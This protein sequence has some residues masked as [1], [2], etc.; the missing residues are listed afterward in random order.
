[1]RIYLLNLIYNI[2]LK[3]LCP[4]V[5]GCDSFSQSKYAGEQ[6]GTDALGEHLLCVFLSLWLCCSTAFAN[7][8]MY[9]YP[10]PPPFCVTSGCI[11][12]TNSHFFLVDFPIDSVISPP[13][14]T[15][16]RFSKLYLKHH[17]SYK[18]GQH[19]ID[20]Q[21]Q[22]GAA[23]KECAECQKLRKE[24]LATSSWHWSKPLPLLCES[25]SWSSKS[26]PLE[27]ILLSSY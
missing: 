5:S 12:M 4:V 26:A 25:P 1:M 19:K 11:T 7:V 13:P 22:A 21:K 14:P 6:L 23:A 8:Q 18:K 15:A 16:K 27:R 3:Y 2:Y 24:V 9:K 20:P 17:H 10:F